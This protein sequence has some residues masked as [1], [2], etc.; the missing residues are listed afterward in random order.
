[1]IL[2]HNNQGASRCYCHI[3]TYLWIVTALPACLQHVSASDF[4]VRGVNP[5]PPNDAADVPLF[6]PSEQR[7][8]RRHLTVSRRCLLCYLA[9]GARGLLLTCRMDRS[10]ARVARGLHFDDEPDAPCQYTFEIK[11]QEEPYLDLL[12]HFASMHPE[13][14]ASGVFLPRPHPHFTNPPQLPIFP[15]G[16]ENVQSINNRSAYV[17]TLKCQC[18]QQ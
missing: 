3:S 12:D 18:Q 4:P 11:H 17:A 16:H 10:G 2:W 1:M 15:P 6:G 9:G 13:V 14:W 7:E 5:P 8:N